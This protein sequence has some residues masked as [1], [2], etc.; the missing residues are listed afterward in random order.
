ME[1]FREERTFEEDS[2]WKL[3][4]IPALL[5]TV[6]RDSWWVEMPT[7][8]GRVEESIVPY[9]VLSPKSLDS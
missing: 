8:K 1:S 7:R 9:T 3:G 4:G 5:E 2:K 6:R